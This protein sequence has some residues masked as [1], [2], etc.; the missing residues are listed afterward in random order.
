M[1]LQQIRINGK[2]DNSHDT[3]NVL[4]SFEVVEPS[5]Q[6]QIEFHEAYCVLHRVELEPTSSTD[7]KIVCSLDD[8]DVREHFESLLSANF[9]GYPVHTGVAA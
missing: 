5:Y 6:D 9:H 8:C 2:G 4:I 7:F 1:D 3:C